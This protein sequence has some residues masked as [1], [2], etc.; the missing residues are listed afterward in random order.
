[1]LAWPVACGLWPVGILYRVWYC[2]LEGFWVVG[3]AVVLTG[4]GMR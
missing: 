2:S 3:I 1:M 4:R